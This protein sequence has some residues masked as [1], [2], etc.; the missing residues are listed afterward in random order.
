MDESEE[1]IRHILFC[2]VL[3]EAIEPCYFRGPAGNVNGYKPSDV[4]CSDRLENHGAAGE[5]GGNVLRKAGD[6]Q[7]VDSH[8][9]LWREATAK[10]GKL[11]D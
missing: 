9:H 11:K 5:R 10:N 3:G 6:V 8:H 2:P 1:S 4:V 7:E